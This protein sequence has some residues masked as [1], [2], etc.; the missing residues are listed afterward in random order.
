MENHSDYLED[1]VKRRHHQHHIHNLVALSYLNMNKWRQM[2][3]AY[4]K[5]LVEDIRRRIKAFINGCDDQDRG[6][7]Y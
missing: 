2:D 5:T 6:Q 4:L 1:R 7:R 3:A